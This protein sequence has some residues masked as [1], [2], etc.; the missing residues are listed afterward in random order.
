MAS[1]DDIGVP[2]TPATNLTDWQAAVRDAIHL[3]DPSRVKLDTV[4]GNAVTLT[5][6]WQTAAQIAAADGG[7]PFKKQAL[8]IAV[9]HAFANIPSNTEW[10]IQV[11]IRDAAN[12]TALTSMIARQRN[13]ATT[14]IDM[15][16][17]IVLP[18]MMAAE[19][20]YVIRAQ[21]VN[22]GSTAGGSVAGDGGRH[23]LWIAR[24][25]A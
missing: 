1:I 7:N 3:G 15:S 21:V 12:A 17:V 14:A 4:P 19:T 8:A 23:R 25:A 6:A 2:G 9:Y 22:S 10:Q 24:S 5:L 11:E 13:Y 20:Q 18:Y 16:Q